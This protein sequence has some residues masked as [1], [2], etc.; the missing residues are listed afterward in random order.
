MVNDS[1]GGY[2]AG[3]GKRPMWQWILIYV[4]VGGILYYGVYYFFLRGNSGDGS[5]GLYGSSSSSSGSPYN[6]GTK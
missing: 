1:K 6:Y 3:Y 5:N 2:G 4:I